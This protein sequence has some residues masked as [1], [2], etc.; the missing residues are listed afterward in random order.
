M[1]PLAVGLIIGLIQ[2]I[3][4]WLPVSSQGNLV[5]FMTSLLGVDPG[6][7]LRLSVFL[8]VGTGLAALLYFRRDFTEILLRKSETGRVLF[9]FLFIATAV[10]GIIGL[11]IYLF[12][13]EVSLLGE[14]LLILTGV[15]LI[16]TGLIQRGARENR[17]RGV[18][19]I[20]DVEASLLGFAQGLSALPGLSRSGLT[21]SVLLMRG[22]SGE[23]ALRI[24][25]LISVPAVFAA[26][27]GL[28]FI[29]GVSTFEPSFLVALV[30]S[31]T[32]A[33]VTIDGLIRLARRVRFWG[34]CIALGLI[35]LLP[36]IASWF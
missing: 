21:S 33:Y 3:L 30:A 36:Q 28:A 11:P 5:V 10:T 14:S 27:F 6:Q 12:A 23:A 7:A 9:R 35:A 29:E 31:F 19:A 18:D 4:E 13:R 22:F 2:G 17:V 24:S 8:H 20:R 15:A 34:I 26:A 32:S 16:V 1:N 25:F